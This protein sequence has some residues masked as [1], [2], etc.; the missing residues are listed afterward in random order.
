[1]IDSIYIAWQYVRSNKIRTA[2][3]IACITL[4]SFLPVSL[5]L[6]LGES[7]RQLMSRA[8][9]TPLVIGAKGSSLDLVMNSL[10]F[11]DEV[12]ELI[13]MEASERV[14]ES[15]LALSIPVYVRFHARGNP[16]VGT[17][18]DYFDFRGLK[19]AEGRNL[20]VLG[21]CVL[22]ARVAESLALKPGDSLL[23]SPETLFDLAGV[24]PLKMKVVGVLQKSHTSDDLAVFADIKTTW[25]IQGLGHGH[26]DV[27]KLTDPT[28]ILKRSESNVAATAKLYHHTEIT[29]KNI[30]SFHF[31]GNTSVYPITAVIAVPYD[32]KS[33]TILR[34]R[35][36]SRNETLQIIKPE[37]VI[38]GLLQNIF[39]IKNV[40]DAVISVV[41]LA[42]I[43]AIILV[44]ALSLRLRQREIQ[45]IFK[46][47][48]SRLTIAR[49]VSSEIFIIVLTS[50]LLCGVMILVVD[51]I[52]NNLVRMLF[53]R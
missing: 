10:Y 15:G 9:S 34:G 45:T 20:A 41:A 2:T 35:Y 31:H 30:D 7:E 1:M 39:R 32:D 40:L 29:K 50:G 21:D 24:Y 25:V 28:L 12:P 48:C 19:V 6:L 44:F 51:Q 4:I 33:G 27:T 8:V 52:S 17:S 22:G 46:L 5:Q 26:Q 53:I 14:M 47:G 23:S 36:L 11:S 43:L 49:L 3:L 42:T 13:S 38:D 16:I 37:E 18:L